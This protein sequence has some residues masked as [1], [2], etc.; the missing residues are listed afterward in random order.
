MHTQK[1]IGFPRPAAAKLTSQVCA[2]QFLQPYEVLNFRRLPRRS[3]PTPNVNV[4]NAQDHGSE[5]KV[6]SQH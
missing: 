6:A 4:G 3:P 5:K 2:R 1:M